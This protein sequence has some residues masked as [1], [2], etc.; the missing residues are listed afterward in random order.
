MSHMLCCI[1][2]VEPATYKMS[3]H[4]APDARKMYRTNTRIIVIL[5]RYFQ[6]AH[7]IPIVGVGK[8]GE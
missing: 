2:L 5:V 6:H 4:A 3:P 1:S 8:R 7:F